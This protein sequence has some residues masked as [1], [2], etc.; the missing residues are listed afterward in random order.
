MRWRWR[1]KADVQSRFRIDSDGRTD[2]GCKRKL[3]EDS[4]LMRPDIGLWVVAD[5]MGGHDAGDLASQ[6]VVAELD[7]VKIASSARDLLTA[8]EERVIAANAR[9]REEAERRDGAT[10]GCTLALLIIYEDAFA[11]VW[12]G[13]SRV[14]RVRR[15]Q[16]EQIS[17]DH[18]EAQELVDLGT[19][20]A[21]EAKTWPR[22]NVI[23]RAIGVFDEPELEMQQGRIEDG[24]LF[25]LCSD[26]LTE[27]VG[28]PEILAK[29]NG[30]QTGEMVNALIDMTLERG[31]KDNV[32]V[33]AVNCREVTAI[34]TD[35]SD[36]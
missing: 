11:C 24:D 22:K 29:A 27:H 30:Q 21:D 36:T 26:G 33:I 34:M 32:T 4:L 16:I 10:I 25:V 6:T 2:V 28:D 19:L 20:T 14:Y 8:V 3:N 1:G 23:T 7:S 5:G 35:R 18:T 31:A 15:G 17:R 12:S 13:D 9:L